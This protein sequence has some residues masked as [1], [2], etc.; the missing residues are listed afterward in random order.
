M[1]SW[2]RAYTARSNGLG[3]AD[4]MSV[5]TGPTEAVAVLRCDAGTQR[6]CPHC[7]GT[8]GSGDAPHAEHTP[9]QTRRWL[10]LVLC[11]LET[12]VAGDDAA[13]RLLDQQP[14]LGSSGNEAPRHDRGERKNHRIVSLE[15]V[16]SS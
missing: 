1:K 16:S 6:A 9:M 15:A 13:W 2:L 4:R 7:M 10:Q 8:V 5:E 11:T 12:R 14:G 3:G